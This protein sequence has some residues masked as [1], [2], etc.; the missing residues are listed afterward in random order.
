MLDQFTIEQA[1][2]QFC[3][4]E[5]LI[6]Y[7][8]IL[9]PRVLLTEGAEYVAKNCE[10]YW[11]MD[12]I[13]SHLFKIKDSFVVALLEKQGDKWVLTLTDDIPAR[14]TYARQVISYSD[15][16]LPE[17]KFYVVRDTDFS[18]IMLPSEY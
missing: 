18:T 14:S 8:P 12:A 1:L 5:R 16:P 9:F 3:G 13:A 10:A 17:I 4:S 7:N 11:L 2:P 6:R 15:F